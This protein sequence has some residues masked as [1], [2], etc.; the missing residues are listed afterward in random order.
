MQSIQSGLQMVL[1]DDHPGDG[2]VCVA[3]L[4][5]SFPAAAGEEEESSREQ[6]G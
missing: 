2:Q 6:Q 4:S 1:R 3:A 5:Q